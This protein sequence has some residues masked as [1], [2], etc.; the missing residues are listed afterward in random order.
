MNITKA[1]LQVL[2]AIW[3]KG[4]RCNL[5]E[6]RSS[7]ENRKTSTICTLLARL[8]QKKIVL[9]EKQDV[10]VYMALISKNEYLEHELKK[11]G[12]LAGGI[13]NLFAAICSSENFTEK[14]IE[15]IE[16]FWKEKKGEL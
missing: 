2:E 12:R 7:L 13:K 1:E 10:Y 5:S 3:E 8:E 6:I 15:E 4:D 16:T 11:M 9:K 14:D